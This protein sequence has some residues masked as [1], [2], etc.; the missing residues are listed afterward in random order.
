MTENTDLVVNLSQEE[1]LYIL[2]LIQ[3]STILGI[4]PD[5]FKDASEREIGVAVEVAGRA[6]VARGFIK[7]NGNSNIKIDEVPLSLVG[8]CARPS[9]SVLI[10][11]V[12]PERTMKIYWHGTEHLTVE[13]IVIAP[14]IHKLRALSLQDKL[15][16][17]LSEHLTFKSGKKL[18]FNSIKKIERQVYQQSRDFAIKNQSDRAEQVL[19]RNGVAT[20]DAQQFV[21]ML[22]KAETTY[23][24]GFIHHTR[25]EEKSLFKGGTLII[26]PEGCC[27]VEPLEGDKEVDILPFTIKSWK[28]WLSTNLAWV[29]GE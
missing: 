17:R 8:T 11:I 2:N 7:P 18:Q 28:N 22:T 27:L 23:T 19:I 29:R 13:H 4:D 21:N 5:I 15:I 14:G 10:E 20:V 24:I 26:S 1:L 6:L 16:E 3:A 9:Y 12:R 25:P